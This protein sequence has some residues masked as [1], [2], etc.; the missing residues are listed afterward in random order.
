MP[1]TVA[2]PTAQQTWTPT[3]PDFALH[4]PVIGERSDPF[5]SVPWIDAPADSHLLKFRYVA[6]SAM[7]RSDAARLGYMSFLY[8]VFKATDKAAETEYSYQFAN[9]SDGSNVLAKMVGHPDPGEIVWSDLRRKK[10]PYRR[11]R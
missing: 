4:Q 8:V 10:V 9:E 1:D 6:A 11:E 5:Q 2:P 3:Y 7:A